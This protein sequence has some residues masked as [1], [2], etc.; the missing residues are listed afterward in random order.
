MFTIILADIYLKFFFFADVLFSEFRFGWKTNIHNLPHKPSNMPGF[1][2][3][4]VVIAKESS[5][6]LEPIVAS[7]DLS[8]VDCSGNQVRK[9]SQHLSYL[10]TF[11]KL[12]MLLSFSSV[13][14]KWEVIIIE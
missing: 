3:F 7:F 5:S 8:S 10:A 6:T 2:T 1:Q 12:W 4:M 14:Q 13:S 11:E 9:I